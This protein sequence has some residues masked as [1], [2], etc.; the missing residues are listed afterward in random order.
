[1]GI[2]ILHKYEKLEGVNEETK[3]YVHHGMSENRFSTNYL[4]ESDLRL[5][6]REKTAMEK[7]I[8]IRNKLTAQGA[9]PNENYTLRIGEQI[10]NYKKF[11]SYRRKIKRKNFTTISIEDSKQDKYLFEERDL[12]QYKKE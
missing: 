1:M 10:G 5:Y 4:N 6:Q 12:T 7:T 3:K 9:I 11:R 8:E 2:Q